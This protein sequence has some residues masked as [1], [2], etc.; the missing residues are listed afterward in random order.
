MW[1]VW[2]AVGL[3]LLA[4]VAVGVWLLS[5]GDAAYVLASDDGDA[6]VAAARWL[7]FGEPIVLTARMAAKWTLDGAGDPASR[8][9]AAYWLFLAAQY[10]LFGYQH[11]STIV[12]Q[13][14]LGAAGVWAAYS[15][16]RRLLAPPWPLVAAVVIALSSTLV[17]LS[18]ALYAEALYIPLLLLAV[19]FV[20]RSSWLAAGAAG[21]ALGLA[22]ALR[23]LALPIFLVVV[24]CRLR[25]ALPMA[26]GLLLALA[27]FVVRDLLTTGHVAVFTAGGEAAFHDQ[28]F[29]TLGQDLVTLGVDPYSSGLAPTLA[30]LAAHPVEVLRV[31]A[32]AIPHRLAVLFVV[33][34]WAPL[35]EP[36]MS[37]TP[38]TAIVLRSLVWLIVLLGLVSLVR[39]RRRETT[40][41]LLVAA[42][43][44]VP[45]L[46]LGLPLVRY[47]APADPIFLIFFTAGLAALARVRQPRPRP[48]NYPA[49]TVPP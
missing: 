40:L 18:A 24:A 21:L 16:A 39:Q 49:L 3:A 11:V 45:P 44:V 15:L 25:F 4:R 32:A 33:G 28:G 38:A 29:G 10:R 13:S 12:L 1:P 35:F 42:A 30:A 36:L 20:V 47:R 5:H 23:P 26:A 31:F 37:A 8:W 2:L 46:L 19:H 17:Y 7:A 48:G 22:E 9:P 34:G 27:P 41:L 43:I 6:Y 14:A